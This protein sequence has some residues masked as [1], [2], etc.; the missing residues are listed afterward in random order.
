MAS[1]FGGLC[2]GPVNT[3]AVHA[4][5]YPLGTEFH[6]PHGLSTAILLPEVFR[7]NVDSSVARHAAVSVALGATENGDAIDIAKQGAQILKEIVCTSGVLHERC[8]LAIDRNRV[9]AM[10]STALQITRLMKN[11][12]RCINQDQAV[13]IY[14]G[15]LSAIDPH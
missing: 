11:N 15:A 3:A 6:I 14:K 4:L 12:P 10:A 8:L 2:L 9:D 1:M 7:F 13:E 5:A